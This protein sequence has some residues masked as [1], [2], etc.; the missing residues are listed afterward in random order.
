ML[1]GFFRVWLV[2]LIQSE[3]NLGMTEWI[4]LYGPLLH[5]GGELQIQTGWLMSGIRRELK[6][7][8]RMAEWVG[9]PPPGLNQRVR[10]LVEL[11]LDFWID[12]TQL[13]ARPSAV[14]GWSQGLVGSVSG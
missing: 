3:V 14:L 4:E 5:K 9:R 13:L 1:Y 7:P 8:D 2:E 10:T 11:N 12:T 6:G